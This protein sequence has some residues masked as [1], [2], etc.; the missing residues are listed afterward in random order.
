VPLFLLGHFLALVHKVSA[1]F[2]PT[3]TTDPRVGIA[4][5]LKQLILGHPV[6]MHGPPP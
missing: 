6:L 4:A 2:I 3:D 5:G 1:L